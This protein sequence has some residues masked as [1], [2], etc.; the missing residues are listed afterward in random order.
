MRKI[1]R[2]NNARAEVFKRNYRY[3]NSA[4]WILFITKDS[5]NTPITRNIG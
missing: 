5:G 3:S 2:I 4:L 1:T